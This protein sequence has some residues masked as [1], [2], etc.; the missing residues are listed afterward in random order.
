MYAATHFQM[1]DETQMRQFAA[2]YPFAVL[3]ADALQVA[4]VPLYETD[5]L[6]I[7]HFARANPFADLNDGSTVKAI[8]QGP[9]AYI[10][11][12]YYRSTFNVP[13]WN[14][15]AV[16]VEGVLH[17]IDDPD[18]AW[19]HMQRMVAI[20]EPDGSW[21]LPN[22][23]RFKALLNAIR[24]FEISELKFSGIE[25]FNQNKSA[26]DKSSVIAAI[27]EEAADY[28]RKVVENK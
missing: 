15:A 26:D 24:C 22:E 18:K 14:Y 27:N 19:Q 16:H 11:P 9:H 2:R 28:M 25:K 23:E 21:Q 7:G 6:L 5:G 20:T 3:I 8:F 12:R 17:F 13:T 4:H 10:S 1:Q